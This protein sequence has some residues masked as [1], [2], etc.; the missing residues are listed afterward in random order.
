MR[1]LPLLLALV[2][3]CGTAPPRD[4]PVPMD[5]LARGP[6]L[7]LADDWAAQPLEAF[8]R[9]VLAALPDD[10]MTP[11]DK[12]SLRTLQR[13][14]DDVSVAREGGAHDPL[15]VRA[16]VILGRS[17]HP[18]SASVL[19][20]RLERRVLGPERFSDCGDTLAAAALARYPDP[21]RYAQR[22]VPLAVGTRPHPDLEVRVECAATALHAGFTQ[23]IPFLLQVL[24]IDTYA[25][26][27]D[28]RDFAVSPTTAWARGRAAEAL[29][30]HAGVPLTYRF[31]GSIAHREAEAAKLA[32]RL[33][34][35]PAPAEPASR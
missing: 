25:G 9:W 7:A 2:C 35:P 33:L 5:A 22:L 17:R 23:V 28:E 21:A 13:A 18:A 31:D 14:L 8:E 12:A 3:A 29:S 26:L 4:D 19:I 32:E 16:A 34:P 6:V 30:A 1:A 20:R 24:R 11:I 10:R 15:A 27:A